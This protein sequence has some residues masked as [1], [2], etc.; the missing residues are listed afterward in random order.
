MPKSPNGE[1]LMY[2][3][4][5]G[6]TQLEVRLENDTSW[7]TQQQIAELFQSSRTNVIEH[8]RNIFHE[9]ELDESATC[10]NFRQVRGRR[11]QRGFS[12]SEIPNRFTGAAEVPQ[13]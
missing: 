12:C 4:E 8:I 5:D 10:R 2:V 9:G 7:L 3:A 13:K 6:T 11:A 1:L